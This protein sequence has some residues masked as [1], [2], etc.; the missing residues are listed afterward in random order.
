MST[1]IIFK[2]SHSLILG[3]L[4]L[5]QSFDGRRSEYKLH[6]PTKSEQQNDFGL[7]LFSSYDSIVRSSNSNREPPSIGSVINNPNI[8]DSKV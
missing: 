3:G 6:N 1:L 8:D 2:H 5:A 7:K 4:Y